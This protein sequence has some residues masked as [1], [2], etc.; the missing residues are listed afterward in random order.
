MDTIG[1]DLHKRESQLSIIGSQGEVP[2]KRILSTRE[3]LTQCWEER[4]QP[5]LRHN[6][7]LMEGAPTRIV[8][9]EVWSR[10]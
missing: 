5:R 4:Q 9:D 2:E 6:L 7:Q 8:V 3:R 10:A 1:L